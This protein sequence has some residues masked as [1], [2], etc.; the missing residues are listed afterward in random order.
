MASNAP[1]EQKMAEITCR[2]AQPSDMKRVKEI[3]LLAFPEAA[4]HPEIVDDIEN[5]T[6]YSWHHWVVAERDGVV[7]TALGLRPGVMWMSGVAVPTATIGTVCTHPDHRGRGVG[8]ELMGFADEVMRREGVVIARLHTGAT[9]FGFYGRCGYVKTITSA[10][11]MQLATD[12][13]P[14]RTKE[15]AEKELGNAMV[16][17]A[18]ARDA[19]R[20]NDIYEATFQQGTGAISRN[21]HFFLRRIGHWP[22]MWM[23]Y[24]PKFAVV[25]DPADGVVGYVAYSLDG[26][27]D[28]G[29]VPELATLPHHARLART[30]LLHVVREAQRFKVNRLDVSIDPHHALGWTVQEFRMQGE[31]DL[32]VMFLK[33]QDEP[34][35][36]ELMLP[37]IAQRAGHAEVVLTLDL[38]GADRATVGEGQPVRVVSD[39]QHLA[40]LV[41]NGTW[42]AGLEGQG[43]LRVEPDTRGARRALG[44]IFPPT[45]PSRCALDGY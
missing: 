19:T 7:V 13:V 26:P 18:H 12:A 17:P 3:T 21:E 32:A 35:F 22:K 29:I 5:E 10:P 1:T 14:A 33:V 15:R 40:A 31:P 11:V 9:R 42:L 39:V 25:E 23:W 27:D 28:Y 24:A 37:V 8:R 6:W 38:A 2:P 45:H 44:E 36:V 41:Y 16:R 43:A 4:R 20:M 34:R 30:L